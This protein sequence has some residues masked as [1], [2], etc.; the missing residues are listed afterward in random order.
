[1]AN[2]YNIHFKSNKTREY[3]EKKRKSCDMMSLSYMNLFI[4]KIIYLHF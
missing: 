4:I 3:R 2:Y 1:M